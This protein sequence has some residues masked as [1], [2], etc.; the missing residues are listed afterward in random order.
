M[1]PLVDRPPL[2]VDGIA[3]LLEVADDE[4]PEADVVELPPAAAVV[5]LVGEN[6]LVEVWVTVTTSA[7]VF[8][9]VVCWLGVV[10]VVGVT[11]STGDGV[12]VG[13]GVGAGV[14][15]GGGVVVAIAVDDA[16]VVTTTT[17][18]VATQGISNSQHRDEGTYKTQKHQTWW[19][20]ERLGTSLS[21]TMPR[22]GLTGD[23]M[24]ME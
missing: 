21:R 19:L 24:M 5:V 22:R 11:G 14:G 15:V 8:A 16:D 4:V 12:G 2:P 23:W 1:V 18:T 9:G 3:V 17:L 13:V 7:P 6:V 20:G 10:G